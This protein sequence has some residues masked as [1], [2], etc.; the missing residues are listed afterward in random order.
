MSAPDTAKIQFNFKT[1]AGDLFNLYA[2]DE[3]E[4]D[5]LLEAFGRLVG[6]AAEISTLLRTASGASA[7]LAAPAPALENV[8]GFQFPTQAPAPAR[9]S[10]GGTPQC[11]H[12]S[13]IERSAKPGSARQWKAYFCNT[14]QGTPNQCKPIDAKTGKP[15]G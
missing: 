5:E 3:D 12:G 7:A 8:G 13:M 4:A 15:W 2:S 11:A 14:P 10:F 1:A 6:K 9:E